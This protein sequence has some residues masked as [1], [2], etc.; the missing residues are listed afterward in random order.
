MK[1][2]HDW[3]NEVSP[4]GFSGT[5]AAMLQKHPE[6]ENPWAL[7]WHQKNKGNK[8][9]YKEQPKKDSQ[10]DKKPEKKEKYKD[11]DKDDKPKKKKGKK[12]SEWAMQREHPEGLM[13]YEDMMQTLKMSPQEINAMGFFDLVMTF[14]KRGIPQPTQRA[15]IAKQQAANATKAT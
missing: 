8:S 14:T 13:L 12:F 4:P 2:I 7:A 15:L 11:E 1:S 3:F 6:I 9:H 5:V 10:S